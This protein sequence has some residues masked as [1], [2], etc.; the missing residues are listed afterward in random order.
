MSRLGGSKL[1]LTGKGVLRGD[2]E[3]DRRSKSFGTRSA[4][5]LGLCDGL[6]GA[7]KGF[8]GTCRP[9]SWTG[10][11]RRAKS[12]AGEHRGKMP[13]GRA[14]GGGNS[15]VGSG[16]PSW[17]GGCCGTMSA[18]RRCSPVIQAGRGQ[19]ISIAALHPG[20]RL[21]LAALC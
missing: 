13:V 3:L 8:Q 5:G 17:G 4:S 15:E 10:T 18:R 6:A 19:G 16:S 11:A 21:I 2:Y 12:A 7:L 1:L 20:F 14:R 9:R